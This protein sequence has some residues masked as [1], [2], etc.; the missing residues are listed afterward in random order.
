MTN[1]TVE[2]ERCPAAHET[3]RTRRDA[4]RHTCNRFSPTNSTKSCS[5][6]PTPYLQRSQSLERSGDIANVQAM[7]AA[8]QHFSL[9]SFSAAER[10]Y[11][12]V[13]QGQ[14]RDHAGVSGAMIR[15]RVVHPPALGQRALAADC[16]KA[17]H[18][19]VTRPGH[20]ATM[21]GDTTA[22]TQQ[23]KPELVP[24]RQLDGAPSSVC[25][26]P[27]SP[28]SSPPRPRLG[29]RYGTGRR[30]HGPGPHRGSPAVS[31]QVPAMPTAELL[32]RQLAAVGGS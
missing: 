9:G 11:F 13:L 1:I 17:S 27:T 7:E 6:T 10:D 3:R 24:H 8:L 4:A 20:D 18:T 15:V 2:H 19:E 31:A 28:S 14:I 21:P 22:G 25:G 26:P 30:G 12:S 16:S 5:S 32:S 29:A 23:R